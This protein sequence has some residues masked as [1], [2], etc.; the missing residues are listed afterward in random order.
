MA[1]RLALLPSRHDELRIFAYSYSS[2]KCEDCY[3]S[4]RGPSCPSGYDHPAKAPNIP[5]L[6]S[7]RLYTR[8][9]FSSLAVLW[10]PELYAQSL[11]EAGSVGQQ[12]RAPAA[13]RTGRAV[14]S[15]RQWVMADGARGWLSRKLAEP[16]PKMVL[17]VCSV[18][19]DRFSPRP[20]PRPANVITSSMGRTIPI[21]MGAA[22][23]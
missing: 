19:D 16:V 11:A 12:D 17:G 22:R 4:T 7:A 2:V 6:D 9:L 23:R 8:P 10:L 21:W 1:Y 3:R 13:E 18:A 5:D 15:H 14:L 20:H